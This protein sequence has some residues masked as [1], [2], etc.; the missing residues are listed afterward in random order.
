MCNADGEDIPMD[1][2]TVPIPTHPEYL[3]PEIQAK[4]SGYV[5]HMPI[6]E[7]DED[8]DLVLAILAPDPCVLMRGKPTQYKNHDN[9]K[10][11]INYD[12][13]EPFTQWVT[14]LIWSCTSKHVN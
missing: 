9:T 10:A 4:Y 11:L 14:N 2:S 13:W 8:I 5:W 12:I 3:T 7:N 6:D 1:T